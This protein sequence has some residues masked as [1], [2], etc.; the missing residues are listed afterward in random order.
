MTVEKSLGVLLDSVLA[1]ISELLSNELGNIIQAHFSDIPIAKILLHHRISWV[2]NNSLGRIK[3]STAVKEELSDEL[4]YKY[5]T[6]KPIL[7]HGNSH[8][9]GV[10]RRNKALRKLNST[11]HE[12]KELSATR[13]SLRSL[14]REL[15]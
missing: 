3:E 5:A 6:I 15:H 12:A 11:F 7:L 14:L 2:E 10:N 8:A 9:S 1:L 13:K 4:N